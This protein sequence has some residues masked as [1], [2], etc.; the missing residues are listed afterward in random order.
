MTTTTR[1]PAVPWTDL[2]VFLALAFGLTWLVWTPALLGAEIPAQVLITLSMACV[3]L[4][5]WVTL[6]WRVRPDSVRA[7]T[8]LRPPAARWLWPALLLLPVTNLAALALGALAGTYEADLTGF[9]GLRATFAPNTL[10]ATG[11]PWDLIG[12]A[13]G[14][15]LLLLVVWLPMMWCEEWGWRG[16][17]LPR[18]LPLGTWPALLASGVV[19]GLWHLPIYVLGGRDFAQLVPFLVF[20]VLL[21]VLVGW[22]RLA[23][24]SVWPCVLAHGVNNTV[25]TATN[26]VFPSAEALRDPEA[27]NQLG[28]LGWPGWLALTAVIVLVFATGRSRTGYR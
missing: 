8:A 12:T 6:R 16:F 19:W 13:L 20:T 11:I 23:S 27:L 10:G 4:A 14:T 5:T 9:S 7:A 1:A 15:S 28:F 24:G 18:L 2:G 26:A 3:A 17:L 25:V 22:L 21:G